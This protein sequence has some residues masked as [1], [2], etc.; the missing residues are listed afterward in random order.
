M[1]LAHSTIAVTGATGFIGRYIVRVLLARGARVVGVVRNPDK[2]P[3][4][5]SDGVDLRRA[6]LT[7]RDA[8]RAAFAG[9]DAVIANAGLISA[10][11]S[12][13][14]LITANLE[15]VDN[16]FHAAAEAGV[17]RAIYNSSATVYHPKRGHY[18]S[19]DDPLRAEDAPLRRWNAYSVSKA[20]GEREAWRLARDLG[21]GLSSGRPSMVY[22]AFDT[23]TATLWFKRLAV[24]PVWPVG[25][26]MSPVYAGDIGEAFS[27][28]LERPDSI[29]R[30]Y[31]I[32]GEPGEVS[33]VDLL[34][35]WR[36]AGGTAFPVKLPVPVF[37]QRRYAIDKAKDELGWSN[38]SVADAFR[39]TVAL[40][41]AARQIEP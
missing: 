9:V 40:E 5:R 33:W 10:V 29:G 31:N 7:D 12:R 3:S 34:A 41:K 26:R 20:C 37:V 2:V 38:R 28:M 18:Y 25:L 23:G 39:E 36:G 22:G 17:T 1:D 16:V 6:D 4:M 14:A 21:I 13:R 35:A 8:L 32:C 19:E 27:R 15:G 24:L 30:A 11:K